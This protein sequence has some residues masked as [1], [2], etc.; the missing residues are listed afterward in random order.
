M[1]G[2][3]LLC[4]RFKFD[5]SDAAASRGA[6]SRTVEASEFGLHSTILLESSGLVPRRHAALLAID[7][8]LERCCCDLSTFSRQHDEF[9]PYIVVRIVSESARFQTRRCKNI[10]RRD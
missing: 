2:R 5:T 6:E 9:D 7:V 4:S 10:K 8:D 3:L 1:A